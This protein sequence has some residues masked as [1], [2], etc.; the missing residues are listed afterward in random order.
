MQ[1][2]QG[3]RTSQPP[4]MGLI[5]VC[6]KYEIRSL[7]Q[8]KRW[9]H[10]NA[11]QWETQD[12]DR[13]AC[14]PSVAHASSSSSPRV[15]AAAMAVLSMSLATRNVLLKGQNRRP[16]ARFVQPR[17]DLVLRSKL[18][19]LVSGFMGGTTDERGEN[20]LQ[21]CLRCGLSAPFLLLREVCTIALYSN[22]T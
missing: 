14:A 9:V 7:S 12:G 2:R 5:Q 1:R 15:F 4:C 13:T 22:R 19:P 21:L 3:G 16:Q 8:T 11:S 17:Q 10:E 20:P 6:F 18:I